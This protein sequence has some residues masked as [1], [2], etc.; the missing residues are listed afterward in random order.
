MY[1]KQKKIQNHSE[2]R[3]NGKKA[4]TVVTAECGIM[5]EKKKKE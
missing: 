1:S 5:P 3:I 4:R 2:S